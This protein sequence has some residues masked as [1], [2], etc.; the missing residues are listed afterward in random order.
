MDEDATSGWLDKPVGH[1][2][3]DKDPLHRSSTD[4]EL[5]VAA[6]ASQLIQA[7]SAPLARMPRNQRTPTAFWR[8]Q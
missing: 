3:N 1:Q 2:R 8:K 6:A 5:P 4:G 7:A